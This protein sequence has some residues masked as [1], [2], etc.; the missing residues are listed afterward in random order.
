MSIRLCV[1]VY[2]NGQR[3]AL[4]TSTLDVDDRDEIEE[5]ML[6]LFV[7]AE[8]LSLKLEGGGVLLL[9]KGA[10]SNAVVVISEE[11]N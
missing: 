9:Q 3:F 7:S 1:V 4:D 8:H 5:E 11:S 2:T 10:L 6:R